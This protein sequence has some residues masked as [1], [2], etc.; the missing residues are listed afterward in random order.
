MK[1]E[2]LGHV[3]CLGCEEIIGP[4]LRYKGK[5][6]LYRAGFT[7]YSG[8]FRCALCG[9]VFHFEGTKFNFDKGRQNGALAGEAK[10]ARSV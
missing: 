8:F 6:V 10:I 1:P 5:L 2:L 9:R 7:I 3:R 4:L